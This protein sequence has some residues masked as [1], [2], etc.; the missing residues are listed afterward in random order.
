ML[1]VPKWRIDGLIVDQRELTAAKS[2]KPWAY[3][4]KIMA[5][6]GTYELITRDPK[7]HNAVGEGEQVT[8]IGT[9]DQYKGELKLE[10]ESMKVVGQEDEK[11]GTAGKLPAAKG[12][13][14]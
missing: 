11:G 6:G 1:S 8:A 7:V 9:F 2:Q 3:S 13:A 10:V 14:A 12:G 4:T 5:L